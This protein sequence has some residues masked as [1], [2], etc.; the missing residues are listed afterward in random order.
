M[1][2]VNAVH[3]TR[4]LGIQQPRRLMRGAADAIF[5]IHGG[6]KMATKAAYMVVSGPWLL[7]DCA[8]NQ[9]DSNRLH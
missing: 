7:K 8:E 6:E 2:T 5:V 9:H 1:A 3:L 4:A